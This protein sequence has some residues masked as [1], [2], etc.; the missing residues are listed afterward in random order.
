MGLGH[1]RIQPYCLWHGGASRDRLHQLRS[2]AE[3]QRRGR[4]ANPNYVKVYEKHGRVLEILA[5]RPKETVSFGELVRRD[6]K[7]LYQGAKRLPPLPSGSEQE[8]PAPPVGTRSGRISQ[9]TAVLK[10]P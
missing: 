5:Q 8:R 3:V 2:L 6:F 4:W 7:L 1:L 10:R 9:T